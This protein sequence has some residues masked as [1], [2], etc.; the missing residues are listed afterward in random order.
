MLPELVAHAVGVLIDRGRAGEAVEVAEALGSADVAALLV[1]RLAD[2][3]LVADAL[4]VAALPRVQS[5]SRLVARLAPELDPQTAVDLYAR[6]LEG[7]EDDVA[8]LDADV[9]RGA[10][11]QHQAALLPL[12]ARA[13]PAERVTLLDELESELGEL[14]VTEVFQ[15]LRMIPAGD[16]MLPADMRK[17][18]YPALSRVLT[19]LAGRSRRSAL[20]HLAELA[21]AFAR[22]GGRSGAA[23]VAGAIL[24]I[25]KR[26]P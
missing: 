2:A 11:L 13:A 9:R 20:S 3:G 17:V 8:E 21:P 5:R 24:A 4:R 7:I 22:L 10:V 1:P 26:W 16:E 18:L 15:V 25:G 12:L 6:T 23:E 14:G 19:D